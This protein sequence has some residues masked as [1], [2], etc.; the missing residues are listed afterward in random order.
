MYTVQTQ[1]QLIYILKQLRWDKEVANDFLVTLDQVQLCSGFV[2]PI[3]EH[4]T[5]QIRYLG[6]SYLLDVRRR[7]NEIDASLWIEKAWT[8]HLQRVGDAALMERFLTIKGITTAQLRRANTVRL[9]LRVVT[10]ADLCD[11]TGSYIPGGMLTG[12]WQAGSDLLWPHQP[13][14]PKPYFAT[15]RRLL[16]LTF[17]SNTPIDHYYLDS[18][19]LDISLGPWLSVPR[20]TWFPV[21]RTK[22]TLLWRRKDDEELFVL[23]RSET[24][25]FYHYSHTTRSLP[26]ESHPISYQQIGETIWTQRPYRMTLTPSGT[27]LPPGH[28]IANTLS[29]PSTDI[30]TIGSDGS[31]YLAHEVAACAWMIAE[32]PER[33]ATACILLSNI[34]SIS[35][36]RSELEGMYRSLIHVCQLGLT[37]QEIHQWCDNE[38][39][40]ND[41]NRPL[42]TPGAMVKPDADI[43]LAIHHLRTYME[44]RCTI[45][46]R[47][48]YGHQDTRRR[49]PAVFSHDDKSQIAD[50]HLSS[51]SWLFPTDEAVDEDIKEDIPTTPTIH[52]PT[53]S[54]SR[55][56]T[57]RSAPLSVLSNIECDRLATETSKI[58]LQGDHRTDLPP[59]L[60]PP[61]PGTRAMLRIGTTWITSNYKH[62]ILS[63]RWTTPI[64]KYCREKYGWP[65]NVVDDIAWQS[66]RAARNKCS[67]TQVTQTSKIMHDW[68]PVMH[69]QAHT[70]GTAQCPSC[71]HDDETLDH[72][73]SGATS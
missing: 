3:M 33:S 21:Y 38:S 14:P 13:L 11:P 19:R 26:L 56:G 52:D 5:L 9:Y 43:L 63:A 4:P 39:A 49:T 32:T 70:T 7:L 28:T 46:C 45:L 47:H 23:V 67:P 18:M 42:C 36:Y 50:D 8:P 61:Y 57:A 51:P 65:Q 58:A 30:I 10:I 68:L 2:L 27:A 24:S 34:S 6:H 64:K 31:V 59:T 20:T 48:I 1:T 60:A 41:S 66:I 44:S 73:A 35:S 37:P 16:R 55:P 12:D 54:L 69:M 29:D 72:G 22:D 71:L 53:V 15:F 62:H 40:V 17:C 25:G